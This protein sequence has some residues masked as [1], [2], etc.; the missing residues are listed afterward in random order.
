MKEKEQE[1]R[2]NANERRKARTKGMENERQKYG[3]KKNNT[4]KR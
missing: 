4:G 3:K 1:G 2:E